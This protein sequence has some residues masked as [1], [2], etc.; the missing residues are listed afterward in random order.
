MRDSTHEILVDTKNWVSFK[1]TCACQ[2]TDHDLT[3]IVEP[4][5]V[6][7]PTVSLYFTMVRTEDPD[8][9]FIEKFFGRIKDAWKIITTGFLKTEGEFIFRSSKHFKDFN[10]IL[11]EA[12]NQVTIEENKIQ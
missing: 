2:D 7:E 6:G 12:V 1:T 4:Y 3:V 10:D 11:N 9:S 5:D 8:L